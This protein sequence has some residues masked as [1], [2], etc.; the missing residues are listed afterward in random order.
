MKTEVSS[1]ATEVSSFQ[2]FSSSSFSFDIVSLS[3]V[4]SASMISGSAFRFAT[5]SSS[6]S[7]TI[8]VSCLDKNSKVF[9]SE[10]G[11]GA[12]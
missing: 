1:Y 6:T 5:S 4:I 11:K 10:A 7:G 12:C 8:S 9:L 2:T 3:A